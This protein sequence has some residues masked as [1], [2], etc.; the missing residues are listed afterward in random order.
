M[1]RFKRGLVPYHAS[2]NKIK[3]ERMTSHDPV[4]G[5]ELNSGLVVY[6]GGDR[7]E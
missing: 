4:Q 2:I 6:A 5:E 3:R 1:S 7:F